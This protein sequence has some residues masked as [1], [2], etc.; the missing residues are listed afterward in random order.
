MKVLIPMAGT[1]NRFVQKGYKEPKPLIKVNE[2]RIIEYILEMFDEKDE[3]F[4]ICNKT[5]LL[6]TDMKRILLELRPD[7]TVLEI[8]NHKKGPIYTVLPFLDIV[9]DDED[10]MVC[11]CDNPFVWSRKSFLQ[12]IQN[13]NLDGCILTHSGLHP[14]TLNSTKM[15]FL[16]TK[17]EL[18]LEIKEKACYTDNPMMEHAS[19]GA[20]Y[21]SRGE[22]MKTCFL[23][24][25][26]RDINYNGEYYVT[27]SYNLMI[28][29]DLRVGF[30]DTEFVTVF[31]TPDET[32]SFEAWLKILTSG[33]VK[34]EEDALECYRYWRKYH[35]R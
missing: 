32:E 22:Y 14:H 10:V 5:H 29:K 28:E 26:R 34:C 3:I 17:D 8:D 12:H 7:A 13:A 30:Y 1:G 18:M 11:Y 19:T 9:Q 33:Q 24:T 23:E 16:K 2:K 35:E 15:A 20:Y 21:F 4:F 31:G 6:E 25:I 27:L